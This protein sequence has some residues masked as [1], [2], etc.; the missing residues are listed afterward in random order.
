MVCLRTM[1]NLGSMHWISYCW[2]HE[3]EPSL[4]CSTLLFGD[5]SG[6]VVYRSG[7]EVE[8]YLTIESVLH[9]ESVKSQKQ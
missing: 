5:N 7:D 8:L 9:A 1:G 3:I 4:T 6:E 2:G